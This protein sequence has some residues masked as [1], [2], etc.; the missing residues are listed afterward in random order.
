[1][2]LLHAK[3]ERVALGAEAEVTKAT[4]LGRGVL[5]K[6]RL[7]KE[8]RHPALDTALR[9]E[10]TRTEGSLLVAARRAGVPVPVVYDIDRTA[11]TLRME[12]VAGRTLRDVLA[13]EGD[14]GGHMRALGVLVARLHDAGITHGDLTTSNVLVPSGEVGA[15]GGLGGLG[16]LVLIDFGLGAATMEAE[17][18]GVDLHLLEEALEATQ[19][20]AKEMFGRFLEAYREHA[21]GAAEAI[22]RLEE[23]RTRGRYR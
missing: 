2:S 7:V 5:E 21:A 16:S 17:P 20:E 3:P 11:S 8:Y 14:E 23:I 4:W 13:S 6:R 1:M 9:D 22:R 12:H 18:R 19:A 15:L 10:R